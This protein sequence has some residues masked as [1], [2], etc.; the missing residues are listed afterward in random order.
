MTIKF[1]ITT[2]IKSTKNIF[3]RQLVSTLDWGLHQVEIQECEQ[4]NELKTIKQETSPFYIINEFN[5]KGGDVLLN[6]F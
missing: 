5:I 3:R 1:S 6:G 2:K 4:I